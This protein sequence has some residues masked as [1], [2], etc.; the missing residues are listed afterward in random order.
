MFLIT[1]FQI[2]A[3]HTFGFKII[4]LVCDGA[5]TNLALVKMLCGLPKA[6]AP[7]DENEDLLYVKAEFRNPF[8]ASEDTESLL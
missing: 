8:E 6:F 7:R 2:I 4:A 5:S 1:L 3:N